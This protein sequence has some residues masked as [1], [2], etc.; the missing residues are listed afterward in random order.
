MKSVLLMTGIACMMISGC[1]S[2]TGPAV[3]TP[4]EGVVVYSNSF[5]SAADTAG[6]KLQCE[7]SLRQD[8]PPGGGRQSVYVSGGCFYPHSQLDLSGF[9]DSHQLALTCWGKSIPGGVVS[10]KVIPGS[11]GVPSS[12]SMPIHDSVWTYHRSFQ[13][14]TTYPGCRLRLEMNSGGIAEGGMFIDRIEIIKIQ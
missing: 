12:V 3:V 7:F 5:E 1:H 11:E 13:T 6:W 10:L 8:V 14:V 4:P 2:A 9:T